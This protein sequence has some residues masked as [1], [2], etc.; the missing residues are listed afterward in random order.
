MEN[1]QQ[2]TSNNQ[3]PKGFAARKLWLFD[4]GCWVLDVPSG[5]FS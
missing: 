2:P 1:I 5:N 4:V 3:H